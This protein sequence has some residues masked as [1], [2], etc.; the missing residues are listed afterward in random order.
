M[1]SGDTDCSLHWTLVTRTRRRQG[2]LVS[3]V[4]AAVRPTFLITDASDGVTSTVTDCGRGKCGL[5]ILPM[6][7]Q[8]NTYAPTPSKNVI[9]FFWIIGF[10]LT[11]MQITFIFSNTLVLSLL[12]YCTTSK[13]RARLGLAP[14]LARARLSLSPRSSFET[15]C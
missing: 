6:W 1:D 8:H 4:A 13:A 9:L 5:C 2:Q 7:C 15:S 12:L 11:C 14:G 3:T 10:L